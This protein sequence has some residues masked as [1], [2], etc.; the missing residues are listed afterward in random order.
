MK[1]INK[2]YPIGEWLEDENTICS[3][4]TLKNIYIS[5]NSDEPFIFYEWY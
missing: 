2:K 5:Y 3:S 1:E 4:D